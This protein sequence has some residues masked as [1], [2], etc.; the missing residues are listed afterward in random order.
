MYTGIAEAYLLPPQLQTWL[1]QHNPWAMRDM[2]ERL[3][4]AQQRGL[5]QTASPPLARS[6][7]IAGP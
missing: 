7:A 6:T 2:A 4:E 3:L 5:W 1:Q